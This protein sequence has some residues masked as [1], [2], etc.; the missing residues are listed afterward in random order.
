MELVVCLSAGRLQEQ[1]WRGG[2]M[3]EP[4]TKNNL[5]HIVMP[6]IPKGIYT[7]FCCV[8]LRVVMSSPIWLI[9]HFHTCFP[10]DCQSQDH[11]SARKRSCQIVANRWVSWHVNNE[12]V[13]VRTRVCITTVDWFLLYLADFTGAVFQLHDHLSHSSHYLNQWWPDSLTHIRGTMG[14]W[15]DYLYILIQWI[16]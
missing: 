15:V 7:S 9:W 1:C 16:I 10:G 2:A 12:S 5:I 13:N 6:Y 11:T 4:W 14:R 8:C 3:L